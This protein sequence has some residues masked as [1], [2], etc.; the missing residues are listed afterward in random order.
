MGRCLSPCLGD[1]DPNLYRRRLDAALGVLSGPGD[2][3]RRLLAHVDGLV[4]EA[5]AARR[6]ERAAWLRRRRERLVVLLERA[7][8][9]AWATPTGPRLVLDETPEGGA[10]EAFWLVR[11]GVADWGALRRRRRRDRSSAPRPRCARRARR[12]ATRSTRRGS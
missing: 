7:R 4:D 10:F 1:L 3:A 12:T 8:A 11:G 9:A 2:G 6:Y 5:S